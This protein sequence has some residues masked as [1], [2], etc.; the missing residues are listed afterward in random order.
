MYDE[1]VTAMPG[2]VSPQHISQLRKGRIKNPG[3][4]IIQGL[5]I[6][7]DVSPEYFFPAL[8]GKS[9]KP[10]PPAPDDLAD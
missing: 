9:H 6:F 10:L 7:F 5:C 4:K 3:W 2:N 1:V 8:Q